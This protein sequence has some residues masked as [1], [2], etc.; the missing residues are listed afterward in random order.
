MC[1]CDIR[2]PNRRTDSPPSTLRVTRQKKWFMDQLRRSAATWKIWGNS[3]GALD[4]RAD[5]QNLPDGLIQQKWPAGTF[6][7]IGS[8][9]YGSAYHERGEIYDLVRDS[10][11]TGFAI[12]SGDR[13]SFSA[14][15]AASRLPPA[16]FEPVGISFVGASLTSPGAMEAMEHGLRKDHPLRSLYLA[17]RPG[18]K[19]EWT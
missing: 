7:Q 12:V 13:H 10:K 11:I 17:D 16:K 18:V 5:P 2:I 15:Y 8:A 4:L 3:L 6:A 19:P 14:G 9:D 1:Y